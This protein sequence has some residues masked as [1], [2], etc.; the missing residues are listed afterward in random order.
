MRHPAR[1]LALAVL[2]ACSG[3]DPL[4]PADAVRIELGPRF[5]A[6]WEAVEQCS[7]LTGQ[8]EAVTVYAVPGDFIMLDGR[9]VLAYWSPATNSIYIAAFYLT[10]DPLLRH[11][12]LHALIYSGEHPPAYFVAKCGSL[13]GST[14]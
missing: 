11:E 13:V 12:A 6:A 5:A 7:G 10:S 4:A 14:P 8:R 2:L 3:A 9:A 1:L